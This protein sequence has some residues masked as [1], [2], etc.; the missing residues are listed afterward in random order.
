MG[1]YIVKAIVDQSGGKV[2]FESP[3]SAKASAGK[4]E[5]KGTTFYVTLPMSGMQGK[6]GT[7][8]LS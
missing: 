6:Q 5:N 3:A 1:L 4:E 2:W 7:K 8:V